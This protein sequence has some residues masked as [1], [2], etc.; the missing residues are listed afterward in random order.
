[1]SMFQNDWIYWTL[2]AFLAVSG[3][4]RLANRRREQLTGLLRTYVE[5]KQSSNS[6]AN[7]FKA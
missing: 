3:L 6:K 1:M 7:D 4:I 2:G 5:E